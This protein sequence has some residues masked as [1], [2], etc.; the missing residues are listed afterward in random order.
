RGATGKAS[1]V[2][3]KGDAVFDTS[4]PY[5]GSAI[6]G[7]GSGISG[8]IAYGIYLS[9]VQ[10]ITIA[11]LTFEDFVMHAII[12]V[13]GVQSPF[14]HHVVMIDVGEQFLKANPDGMGGG[15]NNG[16]VEYCTME[17]TTGAPNNYTNGVDLITAKNWIIRNNLFKNIRTTNTLATTGGP[18]ALTG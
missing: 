8:S 2:V 4:A 16:I 14:L 9:S 13:A 7:P 5:T 6:W 15:V 3:I 1:D 12:I 18:V 11:D 10:G 17:F